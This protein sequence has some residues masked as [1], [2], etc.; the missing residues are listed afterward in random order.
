AAVAQVE[1]VGVALRAE[2]DDADGLAA[3]QVEVRVILVEDFCHSGLLLV[4]QSYAA[5]HPT[6]QRKTGT[7]PTPV[8]PALK[9]GRLA[10]RRRYKR[11]PRRGKSLALRLRSWYESLTT[12]GRGRL[13]RAGPVGRPRR[14]A[15]EL[16]GVVLI[17]MCGFPARARIARHLLRAGARPRGRGASLRGRCGRAR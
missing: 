16:R 13:S 1:G 2:A 14:V 10:A 17:T 9:I 8:L 7:P 4:R 5:P 3:D 11:E 15:T 6:P 12:S